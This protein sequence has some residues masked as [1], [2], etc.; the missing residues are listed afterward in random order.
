MSHDGDDDHSH[1]DVL[2]EDRFSR[3]VADGLTPD[4]VVGGFK[5]HV[6]LGIDSRDG[7]VDVYL[8]NLSA[9]DARALADALSAAA[10]AIESG[11]LDDHGRTWEV[12]VAEE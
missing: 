9:D 12:E 11:A 2:V 7:S 10:D 1:L 3:F 8:G 5:T 4:I 6:T